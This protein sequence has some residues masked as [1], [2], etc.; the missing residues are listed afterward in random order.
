MATAS[1]LVYDALKEIGVLAEGETPSSTML[2]DALRALNRLIA[3]ESHLS[4]IDYAS[5]QLTIG[6]TGQ[7][8]FTIGAAGNIVA[9]RP[10]K[11]DS[12]Q[13]VL[14]GITYDVEVIDVDEWDLIALKTTT[15]SVPE[16]IYYD[17]VI[18]TGVVYVWPQCTC[19]LNMRVTSLLTSFASSS[20]SLTLPEG[21]EAWLIPALAIAIAPQYPGCTLSPLTIQAE[22]KAK[23]IIKRTNTIVPKLTPNVLPDG[24]YSTLAAIQAG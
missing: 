24:N 18:T 3:L 23:K 15:G 8:S 4:V 6:L 17:P 19:T 5:T 9:T 11:I 14:G 16:V 2:D 1:T 22:K 21:Y 7:S 13:A 12:A 20:T 10:I